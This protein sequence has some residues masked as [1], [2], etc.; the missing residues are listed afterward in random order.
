[1][2]AVKMQLWLFLRKCFSTGS[3]CVSLVCCAAKNAGGRNLYSAHRLDSLKGVPIRTVA[4]GCMACHSVVIST[5]GKVYSWGSSFHVWFQKTFFVVTVSK[6]VLLR[7][8]RISF[9]VW[10]CFC[11]DPQGSW[12][13][14]EGPRI[15]WHNFQRSGNSWKISRVV[16]SLKSCGMSL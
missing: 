11:Q 14:V 6:R 15:L 2:K 12:K 16:E 8:Q 5:D 7:K 13:L 9:S 3:S 1:M 4:S 10:Y